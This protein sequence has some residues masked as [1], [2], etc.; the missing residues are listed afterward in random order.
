LLLS[1]GVIAIF[2]G[3]ALGYSG[4]GPLACVILAFIANVSWRHSSGWGNSHQPVGYLFLQ[5]SNFISFH[6]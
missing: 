6:F 4:A 2:G 5:F 3:K 1:G